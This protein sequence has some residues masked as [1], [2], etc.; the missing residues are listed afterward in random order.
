MDPPRKPPA[1]VAAADR[2]LL[3]LRRI[4]KLFLRDVLVPV[5]L[6]N[7]QRTGNE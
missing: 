7:R 6:R 2:L 1:I 3:D 5:L 4:P